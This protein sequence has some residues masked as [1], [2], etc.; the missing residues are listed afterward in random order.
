MQRWGGGVGKGQGRMK[1]E[2]QFSIPYMCEIGTGIILICFWDPD[3]GLV[4]NNPAMKLLV[5]W[6]VP[7]KATGLTPNVN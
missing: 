6:V 3:L 1:L 7:I 2:T 4:T 5:G